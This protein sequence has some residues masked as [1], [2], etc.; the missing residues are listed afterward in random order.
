MQ[1]ETGDGGSGGQR[2]GGQ[3]PAHGQQ[4]QS[5]E[6]QGEGR[7]QNEQHRP[8]HTERHEPQGGGT[9]R[10]GNG[11]AESTPGVN[12]SHD[13][14]DRH[15]SPAARPTA[16]QRPHGDER[17]QPGEQRVQAEAQDEGYGGGPGGGREVCGGPLDHGRGRGAAKGRGPVRGRRLG[18]GA[19]AG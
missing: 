5:Q 11:R 13:K 10:P 3:G 17:E 2:D 9:L 1:Q 15:H 6:V 19:E 14:H 16:D 8:A 7:R 12:A 18:A 4:M